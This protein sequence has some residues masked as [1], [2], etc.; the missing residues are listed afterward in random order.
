MNKVTIH[1]Q[2]G[3]QEKQDKGRKLKVTGGIMSNRAMKAHAVGASCY[4]WRLLW[5]LRQLMVWEG[6]CFHN[7][8]LE[9]VLLANTVRLFLEVALWRTLFWDKNAAF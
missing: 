6:Y 2:Q 9:I 1:K 4:W 7:I 8:P 3:D 5:K